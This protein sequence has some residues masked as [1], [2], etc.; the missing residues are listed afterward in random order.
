MATLQ[1]ILDNIDRFLQFDLDNM[2]GESPTTQQKVDGFNW[3]QRTVS[4]LIFQYDPKITLTLTADQ[5]SYDLRNTSVVSRKV[6]RPYAVIIN[7]NMLWNAAYTER[8]LWTLQELERMI[9]SW[10]TDSSGTPTKGVYYGNQKLLLHPAPTT[11]VVNAGDNYISGQ[12]LAADMTTAQLASTPDIPEELH[13]AIAFCAAARLALPNLSEAEAW[14]R[15]TAFNAEWRSMA[16][17]M[18]RENMRAIQSWGSTT[19]NITPDFMVM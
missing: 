17:D 14:Q 9:P 19:G 3:A 16:D 13:E 8:G 18:R 1:T 2:Y 5:A 12:Y 6:I 10:R 15:I 7:G 4:K 11:A